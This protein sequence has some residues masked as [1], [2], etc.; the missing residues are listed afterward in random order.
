MPAAGVEGAAGP[1]AGGAS[2][3][4][5]AGVPP[6]IVAAFASGAVCD[7]PAPAVK[8][9]PVEAKGMV[10]SCAEGAISAPLATICNSAIPAEISRGSERLIFSSMISVAVKRVI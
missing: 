2:G 5:T 10:A 9:A 1:G 7:T 4:G 3:N 8:G 6:K